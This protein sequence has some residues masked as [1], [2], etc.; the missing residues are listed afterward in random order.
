MNSKEIVAR[1]LEYAGPERVA[2]SF[3]DPDFVWSNCQV[4]SHATDW[5]KTGENRWERLDEWGNLWARSQTLVSPALWYEEFFPRFKKQCTLA[6][7]QGIKVFMHSCGKI[8]AIVPG[9]IDAGID[10]LQFDQPTLHGID[11]LASYQKDAKITFWCPVDIQ[12]TLQS[13]NAELIRKEARQL[14]D[15]L[16]QHT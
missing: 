11:K 6:H 15:S 10:V 12:R 4:K 2:R 7:E 13:K 5:S 3:G 1:T 9:L 16:F 14:L 8:E